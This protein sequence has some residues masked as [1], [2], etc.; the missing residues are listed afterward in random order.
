MEISREKSG[1]TLRIRL[2]GR[3]DANWCDHVGNALAEAIRSGEHD[4]HLDMREVHYL[5][6]LGIRVLLGTYKQLRAIQGRFGVVDPSDTVRKVLELSG[7]SQLITAADAAPAAQSPDGRRTFDSGQIACEVFNLADAPP[8]AGRPVGDPDAV[9]GRAAARAAPGK[10]IFGKNVVALGIGALGQ[11]YAECSPRFGEF[12][13]VSGIATY[14]P[15]DGSS[16]P[17][18]LVSDASLQPE[19]FLMTGCV[20]E[21]AFSQLVRFE[22]AKASRGAPLSELAATALELA[23][24]RVA[25]IVAITETSSLVGAALRQSPA[26]P[27]APAN[28][29]DFPHIRDWISFTGGRAC[30][31]TTSLIVGFA[32]TGGSPLDP[33]LRPLGN[34]V[35]GHFHAA[36][37]PYRP[38]QK[39]RIELDAT[40]SALFDAHNVQTVLHLLTD[41]REG[42][43]SGESEFHRGALWVA[44]L[45][46][47]TGP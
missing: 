3:L 41:N 17:D 11:D 10:T 34:G 33:L 21:G 22:A 28:R 47:T 8:M 16:R 18:F 20:A 5:S 37:F 46:V 19:G 1:E 36:S 31:D 32:G 14:Q 38:L 45:E 35:S 12:L 29:F 13:A 26:L 23:G 27:G 2:A 15:S 44:P 30:R 42:C 6:S 40:A 39:G 43:G 7:L 24:G 25:V 9:A 4:I